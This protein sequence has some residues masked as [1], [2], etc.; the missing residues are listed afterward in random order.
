VRLHGALHLFDAR[1]ELQKYTWANTGVPLI[2]QIRDALSRNFFPL[3]V[4][5]GTS[6]EKFTRVRHSDYLSKA[7]RSFIPIQGSLFIY[8]HSLGEND[9]H[10]LHLI[11]IGKTD[12]LFVSIHRDPELE[13]NKAIIRKAIAFAALR[14]AKRPLEVHFFDADSAQVWS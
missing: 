6:E 4:A 14:P 9:A 8:G 3:F 13:S 10:I 5:E 7:Y 1:S 12:R 11:G 2:D